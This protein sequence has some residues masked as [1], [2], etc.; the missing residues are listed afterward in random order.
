MFLLCPE[1][2]RPALQVGVGLKLR[3]ALRDAASSVKVVSGEPAGA[4]L[5]SGR[6][7]ASPHPHTGH[8]SSFQAISQNI[9]SYCELIKK[10]CSIRFFSSCPAVLAQVSTLARIHSC[11]ASNSGEA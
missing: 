7:W 4:S 11:T 9:H 1:A 5:V 10:A 8:F 2:Y 6:A 3:V